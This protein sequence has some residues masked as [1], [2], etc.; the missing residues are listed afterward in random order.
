MKKT[1]AIGIMLLGSLAANAQ[2]I[3][4][5]QPD[6]IRGLPLMQALSKRQSVRDF[7]DKM[8]DEKDLADL[9][10]AAMG[11]NRENG[12]L[13]APT[14]VNRQEIR[15]F[16]FTADGISEYLPASHSLHPVIKGDHRHLIA[17]GQD[18][19]KK[20]PVSL[21]MIANMQKFGSDNERARKM[22]AI[23]G[24]IVCQNINLFCAATGLVTV[25]RA[26]MDEKGILTVLG[27]NE[28]HIPIMNN[29]VGY[30]KK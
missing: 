24:G 26:T 12:N 23:D 27:L 7:S 1:L 30:P 13:T 28:N 11:K 21:V 8:L 14:A 6:K 3:T 5:P 22:V 25:P 17:S 18:F 29:P 15:L 4:L 10:W 2:N 16:I 19:A 9:L 20:A